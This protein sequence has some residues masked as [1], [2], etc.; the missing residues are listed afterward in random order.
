MTWEEA[1]ASL[2][3]LASTGL[4]ASAQDQSSAN[5]DE[6]EAWLSRARTLLAAL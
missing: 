6:R 2:V 3:S 4:A 1:V 5:V